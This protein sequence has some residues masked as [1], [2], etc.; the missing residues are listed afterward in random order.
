MKKIITLTLALVASASFALNV[1]SEE[2]KKELGVNI[3]WLKKPPA[4]VKIGEEFKI[5]WKVVGEGTI[6]HVNLHACPAPHKTGTCSKKDGRLDGEVLQGQGNRDY[7]EMFVF[8]DGEVDFKGGNQIKFFTV[9]HVIL[10]QGNGPM[11]IITEPFE[12]MVNK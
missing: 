4:S 12:V 6:P 9:G 5:S 11:N 7:S 3:V 8:K 1:I 2:K 10:D